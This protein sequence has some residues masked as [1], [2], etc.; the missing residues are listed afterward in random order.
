MVNLQVE[1]DGLQK[2]TLQGHNFLPGIL[3]EGRVLTVVC[4][5]TDDPDNIFALFRG[6]L[7]LARKEEAAGGHQV[8]GEVLESVEHVE[9]V[10]VNG[11]RGHRQ[12]VEIHRFTHLENEPYAFLSVSCLCFIIHAFQLG[13][14]GPKVFLFPVPVR[15]LE[16]LG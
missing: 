6:F 11:G 8:S 15:H 9:T 16:G 13:R 7:G 2:D 4:E 10:E 5:G 14:G 1:L 3:S 12:M